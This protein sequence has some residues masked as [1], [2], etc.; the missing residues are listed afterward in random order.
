MKEGSGE[1][2]DSHVLFFMHEAGFIYPR[3]F[4]EVCKSGL[5]EES[6]WQILYKDQI[7]FGFVGLGAINSTRKLIPFAR[8]SRD[9]DIACFQLGQGSTVMLFHEDSGEREFNA[10]PFI[11][12]LENVNLDAACNL[13]EILVAI[14][15]DSDYREN[16]SQ[17]EA[18]LGHPEGSI[19]NHIK[20]LER[21]LELIRGELCPYQIAQLNILIHVHDT[22]KPKAAP[23]VSILDPK[24]HASLA[25]AF[26]SAFVSSEDLLAMVQFHDELHALWKQFQ[27]KGTVDSQRLHKLFR[28]IKDW[29]TFLAFN[30]IDGATDG[31]D[32]AFIYWAIDMCRFAGSPLRLDH[33]K[34]LAQIAG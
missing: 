3:D 34:L 23:K 27:A 25:R 7:D 16:I 10:L 33:A 9:L 19:A 29:D 13:K 17:G 32:R 18:R 14:V 5:P 31:K 8:C 12:W 28:S 2:S 4:L 30:I 22:F 11:S 24:S 21:S 1:E 26:L 20:D 6:S 15:E